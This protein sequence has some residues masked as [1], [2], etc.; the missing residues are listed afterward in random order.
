[1][2]TE[3]R[4]GA[5]ITTLHQLGYSKALRALPADGPYTLEQL[6][7]ALS[8]AGFSNAQIDD[9]DYSEAAQ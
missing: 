7:G 3:Q 8:S 5:D 9:H 1:M 2:T 4:L 6:R